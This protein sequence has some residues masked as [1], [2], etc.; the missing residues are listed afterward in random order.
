M[1]SKRKKQAGMRRFRAKYK[2]ARLKGEAR[3]EITNEEEE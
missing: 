3:I 1:P 2:H